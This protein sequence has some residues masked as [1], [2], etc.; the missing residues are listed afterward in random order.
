MFLEEVQSLELLC[1][2][3]LNVDELAAF[4]AFS[5]DNYTIDKGENSMVLTHAN[6]QTRVVNCATLT[7]DDVTGF[8]V[9]TTEN[10]Y[11]ESF[12]F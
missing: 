3:R 1:F 5:E 8:A 7:L 2:G 6:V 11:S 9:L 12:A 10:L 4:F